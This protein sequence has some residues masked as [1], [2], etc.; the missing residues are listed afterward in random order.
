MEN[1]TVTTLKQRL[2]AGEALHV[3][4]VREPEEYKEFNLGVP[5]IPLGKI[6]S[7]QLDEIDHLKNEEVIVHCRSGKRSMV[8]CLVL[9]TA[10]FTNTKNLEGGIL[11]WIDAFGV[12]TKLK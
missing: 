7:I 9:E 5:L 2:D 6:Q 4:D 8:A 3:I 10:G 11:A 12:D 1:I